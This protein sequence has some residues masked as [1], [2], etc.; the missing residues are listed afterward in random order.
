L[1]TGAGGSTKRDARRNGW[2]NVSKFVKS[3]VLPQEVTPPKVKPR[4]KTEVEKLLFAK[5]RD[6]NL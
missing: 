1:G 3:E 5:E 6:P 2:G 4:K